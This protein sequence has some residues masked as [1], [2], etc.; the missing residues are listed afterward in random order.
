VREREIWTEKMKGCLVFGKF[1][2][3]MR[4]KRGMMQERRLRLTSFRF[5]GKRKRLVLLF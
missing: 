5:Q 3:K 4:V 2:R 1:E